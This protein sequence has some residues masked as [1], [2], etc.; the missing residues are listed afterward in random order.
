MLATGF[1][2]RHRFWI[3]G[4][5]FTLAFW[6]YAFDSQNAVVAAIRLFSSDRINPKSHEGELILRLVFVFGAL[7]VAAA[8]ALRTWASAYLK[9]E[10]VHD[11]SLHSESLVA[12][13][14]YRYLRNPL[15]LGTILCAIGMG[16][17]AS[18]VGFLLLVLAIPG[19]MYRLVLRE[20]AAMLAELGDS[21]GAYLRAVPRLWP[22]LSPRLPSAGSK[23]QWKQAWA[24]EIWF[25]GFAAAVL[26]DAATLRVTV[27][28]SFLGGSLIAYLA[29]FAAFRWQ[30]S[31]RSH[32]TA[33]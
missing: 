25:W 10:V 2:F 6:C 7:T 22:S 20:E 31:R 12:D 15:Y 24:G 3:I 5:I 32:T 29:V 16:L 27:F 18:R 28:Y 1:E 9:S 26:A 21:F 19:F 30:R 33:L 4:L 11:S 14:P 13:G 8:A 23:P 17:L